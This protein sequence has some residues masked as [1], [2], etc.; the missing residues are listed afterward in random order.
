MD[1][2]SWL[3]TVHRVAKSWTQQHARRCRFAVIIII[4]TKDM[5]SIVYLF[6]LI[7]KWLRPFFFCLQRLIYIVRETVCYS[8]KIKLI[9]LKQMI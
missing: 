4:I 8:N 3:A 5:Q 6:Q 1:R 9:D 7:K 2:E